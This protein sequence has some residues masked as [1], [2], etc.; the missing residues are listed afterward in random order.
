MGHLVACN[1]IVYT[2]QR[3]LAWIERTSKTGFIELVIEGFIEF[4]MLYTAGKHKYSH[5]PEDYTMAA[6]SILTDIF[7]LFLFILTLV[8]GR[9]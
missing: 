1:C 4:A 2:K 7:Q 8:G 5:S 9:R 6:F 3:R